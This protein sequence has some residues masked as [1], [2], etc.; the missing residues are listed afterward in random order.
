ML[1]SMRPMCWALC[2]TCCAHCSMSWA[3]CCTSCAHCCMC[4]AQRCIFS[5]HPCILLCA[6]L[7]ATCALMHGLCSALHLLCAWLTAAALPRDSS[8]CC[9]CCAHRCM[10]LYAQLHDVCTAR[11]LR[12]NLHLMCYR[13]M[14]LRTLLLAVC[15]STTASA[16]CASLHAAVR[17]S[18]KSLYGALIP[19]QVPIQGS[20]DK[21]EIYVLDSVMHVLWTLLHVL[22]CICCAHCCMLLCAHLQ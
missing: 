2:F 13:Y 17:R 3:M 19:G 14:S 20:M 5:A 21:H 9:N 16:V 7:H 6:Q 8:H 10:L 18:S 15:A 12:G 22:H 1:T 4:C 11:E